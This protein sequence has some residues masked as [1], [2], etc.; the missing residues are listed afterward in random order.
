VPEQSVHSVGLPPEDRLQRV[1]ENLCHGPA[2]RGTR[3]LSALISGV[4]EQSPHLPLPFSGPQEVQASVLRDGTA[5]GEELCICD[6]SAAFQVERDPGQGSLRDV[7]DH[8]V[9]FSA[10]P[11]TAPA[12]YVDVGQ[13]QQAFQCCLVA[14]LGGVEEGQQGFVGSGRRH[15]CH[16][17]SDA[18]EGLGQRSPLCLYPYPQG[19]RVNMESGHSNAKARSARGQ[20]T[21]EGGHFKSSEA[22]QAKIVR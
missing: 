4:F 9:R 13:H 7:L 22:P 17:R 21:T 12:C 8:V 5:P 18:R 14:A 2:R 19:D 20:H 11:R 1:E 6:R 16:A 15:W 3:S 10:E